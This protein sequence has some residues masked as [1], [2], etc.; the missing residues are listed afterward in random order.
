MV[1]G[2]TALYTAAAT[3]NLVRGT[4]ARGAVFLQW[5][6]NLGR[7]RHTGFVG[8]QL[9][10]MEWETIEG[11]TSPDGS[12]EGTGVFRRARKWSEQDVF[13]WWWE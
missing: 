12:P 1:P 10:L 2:C 11:N 9:S 3:H 6:N 5:S 4:P 7:F 8:D 13:I